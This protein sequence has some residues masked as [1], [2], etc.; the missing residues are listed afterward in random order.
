VRR[1]DFITLVGG[2]VVATWALGSLA[3]RA[4]QS[5][6]IPRIGYLFPGSAST[7]DEA[8]RQG[9]RELGYV[10]GRNIV[11]E[12]RFAEG[13][14]DQLPELAAELV[15]L[16]VDVIVAGTTQAALAAKGANP[17]GALRPRRGGDRII[18]VHAP[19]CKCTGLAVAPFP[20]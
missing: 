11:V 9:L 14:F 5:E 12:Y 15:R 8:F 6:K 13:K 17:T 20:L 18:A 4:Q 1:R 3:A 10:D 7:R 2:A 19:C 16:E